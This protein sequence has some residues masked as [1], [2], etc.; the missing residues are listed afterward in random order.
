MAEESI[1]YSAGFPKSLHFA[2]VVGVSTGL[3]CRNDDSTGFPDLAGPP[4]LL[5][6]LCRC[7]ISN[8]ADD[9]LVLLADLRRRQN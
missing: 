9:R 8:L 2:M 3:I 7:G 5:S 6:L 4:P 1:T